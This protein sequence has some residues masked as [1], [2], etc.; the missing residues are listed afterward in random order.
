MENRRGC[1]SCSRPCRC[2][3]R[4]VSERNDGQRPPSPGAILETERNLDHK[5]FTFILSK[6]ELHPSTQEKD[7]RYWTSYGSDSWLHALAQRALKIPSTSTFV[8]S[9]QSNL[10]CAAV[11]LFTQKD[12]KHCTEVSGRANPTLGDAVYQRRHRCRGGHPFSLCMPMGAPIEISCVC[13]WQVFCARTR[14]ANR[15]ALLAPAP[16]PWW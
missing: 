2:G 12:G 1:Y 3:V 7:L 9:Y 14:I 16:R 4:R 11:S 15:L 13:V 8:L 6:D 10:S 5:Y